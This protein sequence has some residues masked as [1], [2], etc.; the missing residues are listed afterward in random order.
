MGVQVFST[1]HRPRDHVSQCME[2]Q[3]M[4]NAIEDIGAIE[5][6]DSAGLLE[7][8][9]VNKHRN[10]DSARDDHAVLPPGFKVTP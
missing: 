5:R 2:H 4:I 1:L 7:P 8:K 6:E 9:H 10:F 3:M